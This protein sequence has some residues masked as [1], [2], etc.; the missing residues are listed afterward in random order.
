VKDLRDEARVQPTPVDGVVADK[1]EV[2]PT[3]QNGGILVLTQAH[4]RAALPLLSEPQEA[5]RLVD[6]PHFDAV[7]TIGLSCAFAL[8]N[9]VHILSQTTSY[10]RCDTTHVAR[11]N[12]PLT[13]RLWAVLCV[14]R[15]LP[16]VTT[17]VACSSSV[18]AWALNGL[19][20]VPSEWLAQT[21]EGATVH[22]LAQK[23]AGVTN[24]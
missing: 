10:E 6:Q 8:Q 2:C 9:G 23:L 11:H 15:S 17:A 5:L 24:L 18:P 1:I 16:E 21:N 22:R 4:H 14:R 12:T 7:K 20:G 19:D 3:S 13:S